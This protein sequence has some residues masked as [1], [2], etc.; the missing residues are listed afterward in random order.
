ML[1]AFL[2]LLGFSV[3]YMAI[4]DAA[5]VVAKWQQ[6]S[7]A[8]AQDYAAGVQNTDKDPT[9]LAIA[10][11][12]R[13]RERVIAAIDS[14]KVANGL[15]RVGKAGWQQ[16]VSSKGVNNYTSGINTATD[17]AT[18]AFQRLLSFESGL[19]STVRGM[20]NNTDADREARMLA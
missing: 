5:T 4:P 13:M 16:A 18:A 11:I 8:A 7:S 12:P 3:A 15:R 14:G 17:K 2:R 1:K 10:A 9:A 19:Q 20:P 6:R